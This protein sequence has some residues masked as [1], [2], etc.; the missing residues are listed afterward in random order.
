[1]KPEQ[2]IRAIADRQVVEIVSEAA[3]D[4]E[5]I[6]GEGDGQ[7]NAIF[8][9]AFSARFGV[10]SSSKPFDEKPMLSP[11]P[12]AAPPWCCRQ[13]RSSSRVFQTVAARS[14]R[15]QFPATGR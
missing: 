3:R 2:R 9:E 7:R 12:T 14:E 6:R 5:I 4:A 1:M 15:R 8:A 10:L 11:F 13:R